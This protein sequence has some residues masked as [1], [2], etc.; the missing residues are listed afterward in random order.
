MCIETDEAAT[1]VILVLQE[2]KEQPSN[3]ATFECAHS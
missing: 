3:Q 2:K 1:L